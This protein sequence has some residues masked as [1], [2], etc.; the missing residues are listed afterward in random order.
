[1]AFTP[2][3]N[4]FKRIPIDYA[5]SG[6]LTGFT[7]VITEVNVDADFWSNVANGGGDIRL[8]S[9]DAGANELPLEVVKCDTT[10]QK[11][12]VWYRLPTAAQGDYVYIS[13]GDGGTMYAVTDTYGRNAVWVDYDNV[14]HFSELAAPFVDS[15]GNGY[16]I[17]SVTGAISGVDGKIDKGIRFDSTSALI[18]A[19]TSVDAISDITLS[20]WVKIEGVTGP[21]PNSIINVGGSNNGFELFYRNSPDTFSIKSTTSSELKSSFTLADNSNT[22]ALLHGISSGTAMEIY[23]NGSLDVSTGGTSSTGVHDGTLG[24]LSGNGGEVASNK[25]MN[26]TVIDEVRVSRTVLSSDYITTEYANQSSHATF[27]GAIESVASG[28]VTASASVTLPS[29]TVS[30]S[31]SATQPQPDITGSITFNTLTVL[32]SATATLPNP[33]LIATITLPNATA[34]GEATA[35]LPGYSLSA[36]VTMPAVTATG[37]VSATLPQP[38]LSASIT[39]PAISATGVLDA[40]QASFNLSS[41]V[42]LPII[43]ASGSV[44]ATLPQPT[45]SGTIVLPAISVTGY[46]IGG[47]IVI[48]VNDDTNIQAPSLSTNITAETLPTN[49]DAQK[50]S[51]NISRN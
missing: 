40:T 17:L 24:L 38:D 31:A 13:C 22:W 14:Y 18:N 27:Y 48:T 32:G 25:V 15:T 12:V 2:S 51:T 1:M 45:L 7:G 4:F 20:A 28:G 9:D 10:T 8:S 29:L 42:T 36:D 30:G 41:D 44:A 5:I 49:I 26:Q 37:S 19:N 6:T 39:L 46:L 33:D 3:A 43:T 16:D 35:T 23:A 11:L 47:E 34:I 50:L 21:G